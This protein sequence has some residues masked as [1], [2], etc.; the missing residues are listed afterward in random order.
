MTGSQEVADGKFWNHN[1]VD[2]ILV[3]SA[4]IPSLSRF[5]ASQTSTSMVLLD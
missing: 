2:M 4:Y 1:Y 3:W 5:Y